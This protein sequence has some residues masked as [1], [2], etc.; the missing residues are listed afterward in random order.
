MLLGTRQDME[1]IAAAVRKIQ[2]NASELRSL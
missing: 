1:E 2:A